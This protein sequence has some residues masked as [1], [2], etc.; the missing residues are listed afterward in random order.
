M[1]PFALKVIRSVLSTTGALSPSLASKL[2]FELFCFTPSRRPV[3]EKARLVHAEGCRRLAS[4]RTMPFRVGKTSATAYA[5]NSQIK[6]PRRRF[7]V[8]H[9]WGSAAAYISTLA[10]GLAS[11]GSEVVVLDLPGHGRSRGRRLHIRTAVEAIVEAERRFGPF[12]GAIGHSFGG[13]S[14]MVAAGGVMPGVGR[15]SPRRLAV[16][17]APSRIEW[18]FDDFS[19]QVGLSGPVKAELIRRAER[20]T[21]VRLREFDTVAVAQK[22][23]TPLLVLHAEDDKEVGAHHARGYES[24]PSASVH[25]ANGLGHRRIISAPDVIE[26]VRH[27]MASEPMERDRSS[28]A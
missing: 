6:G 18:L 7:L 25:W 14:L 22:I 2:A 24:V 19:E 12:D 26:T 20:V 16:I 23:G 3:G 8:V 21:G 28:A 1:P 5:F 11:D 9:G 10:E 13:A 17:G 15:I 4:A 27:F